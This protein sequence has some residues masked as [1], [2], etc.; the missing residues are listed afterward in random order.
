MIAHSYTFDI[1]FYMQRKF[2][3]E[4][5]RK[6]DDDG[7]CPIHRAAAIGNTEVSKFSNVFLGGTSKMT[8]ETRLATS[9]NF[10]KKKIVNKSCNSI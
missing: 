3:Q 2:V 5:V 8:L 9:M 10:F 1:F 4:A 6:E 7:E